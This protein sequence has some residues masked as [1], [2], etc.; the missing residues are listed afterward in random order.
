MPDEVKDWKPKPVKYRAPSVC[1]RYS[2]LETAMEWG[3]SPGR[4]DCL[5]K[6]EKAEMIAFVWVKRTLE[7]YHMEQSERV[8]EAESKSKGSR[9]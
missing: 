8:A 5:E 1:Q 6:E 4:F 2:E 9:R 3:M 7:H